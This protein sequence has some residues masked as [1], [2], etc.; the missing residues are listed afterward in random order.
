MVPPMKCKY[1]LFLCLLLLPVLFPRNS[2]AQ[3]DSLTVPDGQ[4]Y[5]Q[6]K[7]SHSADADTTLHKKVLG[8]DTGIVK[9]KSRREFYYMNYLDSLLRNQKDMRTDTVSVDEK[10]GRIKRAHRNIETPSALNKILNSFPL[11]I[12]FW[13]LALIFIIYIS[14]KVFFKNGIFIK[15]QKV[16][17]ESAEESLLQLNEVSEYDALIA[18]AENNNEFSQA[19]RYLFLK[20][21]KNLSDKGLINFTADKTNKEYLA[22][23]QQH[24]YYNEFRELT[25]EYEYIWYGQFSIDINEYRKLKEDFHFFDKKI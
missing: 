18:G 13:T 17:P 14:Y 11:K 6:Q 10:T 25:R 21:L 16:I 4:V 19:T 24:T 5:F 9:Y 3:T 22:E 23:M 8:G 7:D 2:Y 20:T 12:F 1:Q 15:K